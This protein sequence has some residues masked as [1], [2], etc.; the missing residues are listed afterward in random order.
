MKLKLNQVYNEIE[1]GE[2]AIHHD[3]TDGKC[4]EWLKTEKMTAK[5]EWTVIMIYTAALNL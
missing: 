3:K 5:W 1:I 4:M 2:M